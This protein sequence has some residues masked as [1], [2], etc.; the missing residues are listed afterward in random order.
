[1]SDWGDGHASHPR[2]RRASQL[3]QTSTTQ[4]GRNEINA[5]IA[6]SIVAI[7]LAAALTGYSVSA[8][9]IA[10]TEVRSV[11]VRYDELD[12]AKPQGVEALYTRIG[13]AARLVCRAD[14]SSRLSDRMNRRNCYQDA[15]GRAVKQ[16]NLPTLEAIHRAKTSS[17]VG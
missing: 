17:T 14:S 13:G 8:C 12:L 1:M 2:A 7:S 3:T 6:K 16:V 9:A 15:I 11:T 10:Y 4:P 5:I